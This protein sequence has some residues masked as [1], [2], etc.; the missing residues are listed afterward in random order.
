[1]SEILLKIH[2]SYRWVVAVCDKNIF[3][4]K[5]VNGKQILD[6]SGEFFNGE[7]MNEEKVKIV[8]MEV[9]SHALSLYRVYGI[10]FTIVAFT[11]LTQD[12]LDFHKDMTDYY[13]AKKLLFTEYFNDSKFPN[14]FFIWL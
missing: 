7:K 10:N 1:M 4:Q 6:I 13:N 2:K 11:N 5:L 9:S 8:I 3:G 12:H 14:D